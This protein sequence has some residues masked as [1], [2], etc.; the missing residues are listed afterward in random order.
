MSAKEFD[1]QHALTL[2]DV[3]VAANLGP[4]ERII[5]VDC[6]TMMPVIAERFS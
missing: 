3:H 2:G 6:R 4:S 1:E 5:E